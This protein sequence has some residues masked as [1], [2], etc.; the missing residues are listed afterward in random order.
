M[1]HQARGGAA[2]SQVGWCARRRRIDLARHGTHQQAGLGLLQ[3][4]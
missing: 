1:R 3:S 2:G 4:V